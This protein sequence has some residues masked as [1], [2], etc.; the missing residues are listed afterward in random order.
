MD[1]Q[2]SEL[3]RARKFPLSDTPLHKDL[4]GRHA[5]LARKVDEDSGYDTFRRCVAK[6]LSESP[7]C[8]E[9]KPSVTSS[10]FALSDCRWPSDTKSE[11]SFFC[12]SAGTRI[13]QRR[14]VFLEKSARIAKKYAVRNRPVDSHPGPYNR[15]AIQWL[16][17]SFSP[18]SYLSPV[19][20][21]HFH[22]YI[23][24]GMVPFFI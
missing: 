16:C 18:S 21:A 5:R 23:L 11:R 17:S 4:A 10:S 1:L 2:L 15:Q 7:D 3:C 13:Q 9:G 20:V 19:D 14:S 22:G 12:A 8:T 6:N 24:Y